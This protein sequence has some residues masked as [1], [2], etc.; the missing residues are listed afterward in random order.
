MDDKTAVTVD[1]EV[2]DD[3]ARMGLSVE[4][5]EEQ[6]DEAFAVWK[7]NWPSVRAFLAVETQWR[8]LASPA[9]IIWLGLDYTAVDVVLRRLQLPDT[10]FND[11]MDMEGAALAVFSETEQ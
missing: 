9:G 5:T 11:L 7:E 3:F 2:A 10:C 4:R 1:D 6:E 8:A